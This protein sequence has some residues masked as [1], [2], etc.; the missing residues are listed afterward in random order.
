[1]TILCIGDSNTY[2]FDPRSYLGSRYPSAV[3]WTDRIGGDQVINA[4]SSG[5]TVKNAASAA[6]DQIRRR[7]PALTILML[8]T[9]DLLEG[10][11]AQV[12][13]RRMEE[14]LS[15]LPG[16]ETKILL[17]APPPL[18]PGEW[19]Q[20]R[21]LA[22]ESKKLAELYRQ[23]AERRGLGF[24]DAGEWGVELCFDGVHFTPEGH[25]A[26]AAGL[27]EALSAERSRFKKTTS[28]LF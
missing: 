16:G 4:G 26:F 8:G 27:E 7:R 21:V 6:S 20:S 11:S 15:A 18:Q 5:L 19:V 9:N 24:A 1:M 14:L 23:I 12:T 3:R 28:P 22:E 13:A 2:G 25:A 17:I 10:A